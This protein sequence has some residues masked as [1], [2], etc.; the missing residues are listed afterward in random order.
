MT[1]VPS[2]PLAVLRV[3][4]ALRA[5]G[6]D[7]TVSG[8]PVPTAVTVRARTPRQRREALEVAQGVDPSCA[9]R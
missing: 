1:L 6:Y 5:A 2:A 8:T 3:A 9:R 7:T 4:A